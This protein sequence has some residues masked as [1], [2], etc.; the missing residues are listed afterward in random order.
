[1]IR[2]QIRQFV[3]LS[4][5]LALPVLMCGAS[6]ELQNLVQRVT[7]LEARSGAAEFAIQG[8]AEDVLA[9]ED[10]SSDAAAAIEALNQQVT[11]LEAEMDG[12]TSLVE[13]VLGIGTRTVLLDDDFEDGIDPAW[14]QVEGTT[15]TIEPTIDCAWTYWSQYPNCGS[16]GLHFDEREWYEHTLA[17]PAIGSFSLYFHDDP[18]DT[19][20]LA[21]VAVVSPGGQERIGVSTGTCPNGDY[22][23]SVN[24]GSHRCTTIPRRFGW[25]RIEFV[26][27]G[28]TTKGYLDHALVFET[29]RADR[30]V[31]GTIRVIQESAAQVL[32]GFAIDDVRFEA[33]D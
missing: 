5:L 13:R 4:V 19:S 11:A 26:R 30:D 31:V 6:P 16:S 18:A 22:Y 12:I 8:L 1:M 24:A 7:A 14:E 28:I 20:A 15:Q 27:T 32:D 33:F 21:Y 3:R 29:N 9:L 2:G 25:H 17:A 10:G 23:F